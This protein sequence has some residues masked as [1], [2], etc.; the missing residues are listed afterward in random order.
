MNCGILSSGTELTTGQTVDTNSAWI[1]GELTRAG[2]IVLEHRTVG[3]DMASFVRAIQQMHAVCDVIVITG[4]LGPTTDDLTRE[5]IGEAFGRPLQL[6]PAALQDVEAYFERMQRPM[7]DSNRKQALIPEGA[8]MVRNPRGT[9]PG[10]HLE[11][12]G[13]H[14]FA[15]PGVPSEMKVM[16][17]A[18]SDLVGHRN[19]GSHAVLRYLRCFGMPEA[20]VSDEL[21]ALMDRDRNPL[22][23]TTASRWVITVRILARAQS[24][25]AAEVIA[26]NEEAE[27]RSRLG[28]IVFG[29]G[30]ATL[31]LAVGDALAAR[32]LQI[33]TAESCTGGLIAK[34]LTDIP[35]SSGWF[36][37][38]FVT[39]ANE[40]KQARLQ[41]DPGLIEAH[42][43]VSAEVAEAMAAGASARA[44]TAYAVSTTGVA[45]PGGGTATKPVGLVFI[46]LKTPDGVTSRRFT[47]GDHF[48]RG[49]I[50]DAACKTALNMVRLHLLTCG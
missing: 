6:D 28:D 26:Q 23:G 33:A 17:D 46:G 12:D 27:V 1:G 11:V 30:D 20:R 34:R 40:A 32:G 44:G 49:E 36:T 18:V 13:K 41:V 16:F 39:Y 9:A 42:G 45:G 35:G 22:V 43:A 8:A 4:G 10:V 7:P 5:A 19:A 47:W 48:S 37:E 38:G 2:A 29:T 3:D 15:L 14:I 24:E 31:E 25:D 21:G 50:R